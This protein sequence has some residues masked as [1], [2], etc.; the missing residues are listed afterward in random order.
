MNSDRKGAQIEKIVKWIA[1]NRKNL[2]GN[3]EAASVTSLNRFFKKRKRAG[4]TNFDDLWQ[5]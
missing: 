3:D 4:M 5:K 1:K 2:K